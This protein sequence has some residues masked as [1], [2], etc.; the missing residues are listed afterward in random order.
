[1]DRHAT[2]VGVVL[3]GG[4]GKRMGAPKGRL[5]DATGVTLAQRAVNHLTPLAA[6]V[7][8]TLAPGDSAASVCAP[9]ADG[10]LLL[11]HDPAAHCG[12]LA[13]LAALAPDLTGART[14]LVLA[15]DMPGVDTAVMARLAALPADAGAPAAVPRRS[16]DH[17]PQPLAAAYS[18]AAIAALATAHAA[19]QRSWLQA[20]AET[21][22]DVAWVD[23]AGLGLDD[24]TWDTVFAGLNTPAEW[25]T[26]RRC[27]RKS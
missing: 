8:L 7:W 11:R 26:W 25:E 4:A 20:L 17:K 1:M 22:L 3:A 13:A 16:P 2:T 15:V 10:N 9:G 23:A 24:H 5:V 19:G 21:G 12:P 27:N 18:G 14:V 6:R